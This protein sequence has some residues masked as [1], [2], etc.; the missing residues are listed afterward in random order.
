MTNMDDE[1]HPECEL[2]VEDERS[3]TMLNELLTKHAKEIY[4]RCLIIPYGASNLGMALGQMVAN[5]RFPKPTCVFLDGDSG[6]STGCTVLPGNDAPERV[7]F[8]T[9]RAKRWGKLWS[10]VSRDISLVQDSCEKAMLL[11]EHH[12]WLQ[13]AANQLMLGTDGLWQSM[14]AEWA[15]ELPTTVTAPVVD[16]IEAVLT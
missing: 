7:V 12:D 14:C 10:R 6:P 5:K 15:D 1:R 11:S 8:G 2:Y 16:A 13:F 3:K 4:A 9:L